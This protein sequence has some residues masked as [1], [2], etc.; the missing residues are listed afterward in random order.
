MAKL[1]IDGKHVRTVKEEFASVLHADN[2][3]DTARKNK[4]PTQEEYKRLVDAVVFQKEIRKIPNDDPVKPFALKLLDRVPV[5][6]KRVF[7]K[8]HTFYHCFV[9]RDGTEIRCGEVAFN[10]FSKKGVVHRCY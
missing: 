9:F 1:I 2:I 3:I 8:D 5:E 6:A 10:R 4:R 7:L